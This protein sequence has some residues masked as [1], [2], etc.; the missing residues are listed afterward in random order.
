MLES[1]VVDKSITTNINRSRTQCPGYSAM[2]HDADAWLQLPA[3]LSVRTNR[4]RMQGL[5]DD[6]ENQG[7]LE[8]CSIL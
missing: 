3:G 8:R 1:T 2:K 7:M 5:V 6:A 4:V